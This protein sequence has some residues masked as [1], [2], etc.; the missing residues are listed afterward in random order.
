MSS[1]VPTSA[2]N[3]FASIVLQGS[4]A[5]IPV[6][7]LIHKDLIFLGVQGISIIDTV[8]LSSAGADRDSASV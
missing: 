1:L 7:L 5:T 3:M 6:S 4:G 2:I 8:E